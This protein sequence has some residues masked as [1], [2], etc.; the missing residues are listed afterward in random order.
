MVMALVIGGWL[1]ADAAT[2]DTALTYSASMKKN[3]KA[4]VIRPD[5]PA[6]KHYPVL[7]LLHGAGGDYTDWIKKVPAIRQYADTYG[8]LIV[9][10]DGMVTSWY[11]DSPV[12]PAWRYETYVSH[13]LVEWI[14]AH[15]LTIRDR[16]GRAIT[17]L[18][19][20]GHGALFLSFRHQDVFGAAGSMSGGVD[21]RPFPNNWEI[22]K[23]LGSL[24]EFPQRWDSL[25]VVN[26]VPLVKPG[27]LD[28]IIDCGSDDFFYT[29]NNALHSRLMAAK[30]PH[31]YISRPGGHSWEYWANAVQFQ[32]L[33]MRHFFDAA[34]KK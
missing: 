34:G 20:G 3:I 2:I 32:M 30:I 10:P 18:S 16:S 4:V 6:G 5:G 21:F 31:D 33:F 12:N 1:R 15:Y 8:I 27:A 17:G 29:V 11:F 7:Y 24:Q 23:R 28:L 22:S 26:L 14:D 25:T 9:C 19:M 13:E